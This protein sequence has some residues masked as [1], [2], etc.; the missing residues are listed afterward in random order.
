[1]IELLLYRKMEKNN[2]FSEHKNK[3]DDDTHTHVKRTRYCIV[4]LG[5]FLF[6]TTIQNSFTFLALCCVVVYGAAP[7]RVRRQS[8]RKVLLPVCHNIY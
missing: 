8:N 4:S 5:L 1:M 2:H 7:G 3:W 6:H